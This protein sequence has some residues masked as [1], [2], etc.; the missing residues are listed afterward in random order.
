MR[1]IDDEGWVSG[2]FRHGGLSQSTPRNAI[3][4]TVRVKVFD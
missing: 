4:V 1:G 2:F 3:V